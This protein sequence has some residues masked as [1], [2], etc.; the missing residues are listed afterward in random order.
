V[1]QWQAHLPPPTGQDAFITLLDQLSHDIMRQRRAGIGRAGELLAQHIYRQEILALLEHIAAHD[2]MLTIREAA[3]AVLDS[4]G[5]QRKTGDF[6][7]GESRHMIG[8]R[9]PN[10]HISYYDKREICPASAQFKRNLV[11]RAGQAVD[12]L[13]LPCRHPGC[14]Q[15][16]VVT[17]D[18]EGYK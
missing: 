12:E 6:A 4:Y 2:F 7:A 15:V 3:Q 11:R 10:H 18:C 17:V 13:S 8:L 14:N 5:D 16:V 1:A 9:C